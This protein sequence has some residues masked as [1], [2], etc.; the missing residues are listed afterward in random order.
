MC[1]AWNLVSDLYNG[2]QAW[3]ARCRA[4]R[5]MSGFPTDL[6]AWNARYKA[7]N[8]K[9]WNLMSGLSARLAYMHEMPDVKPGI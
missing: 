6:Q 2:E 5:L 4:W 9:T 3:N 7:W 1:Q 8:L